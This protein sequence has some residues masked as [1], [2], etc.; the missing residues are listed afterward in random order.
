MRMGWQWVSGLVCVVAGLA[1]S[2][3]G[4]RAARDG[5]PSP[6]S[7]TDADA[8]KTGVSPVPQLEPMQTASRCGPIMEPQPLDNGTGSAK[9]T[10]LALRGSMLLDASVGSVIE[11]G[12]IATRDLDN[13]HS[14]LY[15]R[16]Y[17]PGTPGALSQSSTFAFWLDVSLPTGVQLIRFQLDGSQNQQVAWTGESSA[18]NV[19]VGESLFFGGADD[20]LV[21]PQGKGKAIEVVPHTVPLVMATDGQFV[22]W[23]DC[24]T[25]GGIQ[26]VPVVGGAP[27]KIAD[28]GC[29]SALVTDG[30]DVF[31][32]D[33]R[34]EPELTSN[35]LYR[36]A[37][38]GGI[39]TRMGSFAPIVDDL[40]LDDSSVYFGVAGSISRIDRATGDVTEV[41]AVRPAPSHFVTDDHCVYFT[42]P[43]SRQIFVVS[44]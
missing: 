9:G 15:V 31:F 3:C 8:P 26:R 11:K 17:V 16:G 44:K 5:S 13:S 14:R 24:T 29:P 38:D 22:Y 34:L 43:S 19:V 30:T 20:L 40:A 42:S 25:T 4:G 7:T 2:G 1:V 28:A 23:A 35:A 33:P 39:P 6:S 32:L 18:A 37:A 21:L 10:V 27:Q 36:V 41:A 12:W